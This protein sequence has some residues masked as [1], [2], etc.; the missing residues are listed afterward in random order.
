VADQPLRSPQTEPQSPSLGSCANLLAMATA[1]LTELNQNVT[2]VCRMADQEDVIITRYDRPIYR[3]SRIRP[4]DPVDLLVETGELTPP[5]AG[6]GG[7]HEGRLRVGKVSGVDS[8]TI[9]TE[10][11]SR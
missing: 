9:L 11:R 10:M 5:T 8:M 1:T 3:L 2:A 7:E 4:S 6:W